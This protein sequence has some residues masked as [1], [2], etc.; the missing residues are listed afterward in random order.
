[1]AIHKKWRDGNKG[2][3]ISD[4]FGPRFFLTPCRK[5]AESRKFMISDI[6]RYW[7]RPFKSIREAQ[8]PIKR[9][10]GVGGGCPPRTHRDPDT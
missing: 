7:N 8:R 6:S 2:K 1:M 5:M 9:G 4:M 3:C 10:G